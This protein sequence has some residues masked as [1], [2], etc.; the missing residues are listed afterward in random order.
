MKYILSLGLLFL[1]V[2]SFNQKIY[3]DNDYNPTKKKKKAV[4]YS[5]QEIKGELKSVVIYEMNGDK[6]SL[7]NY[8]H[9]LKHGMYKL[10]Y[11]NGELMEKGYYENG[12]KNGVSSIYYKNGKLEGKLHYKNDK[13][14]GM[15]SSYYYKTGQMITSVNYLDDLKEGIGYGYDRKGNLMS[16]IFYSNDKEN[17]LRIRFHENRKVRDS[18]RFVDGEIQ[19]FL[20]S[21]YETGEF[22]YKSLYKDNKIEG[23]VMKYWENGSKRDSA[24]YKN[25]ELQG[26]K[27]SWF[28]NGDLDKEIDFL[29]GKY[30][31][32]L[33]TYW[34]N[35]KVKRRDVYENDVLIEGN[36][37]SSQGLDTAF[38][39]YF[40]MPEFPGGV[41]K[42]YEF[43][44]KNI[45]YP[46]E[47]K[48]S[49]TKGKVY[50]QFVVERSGELVDVVVARGIGNGC[51]ME[52]IRVVKKMPKWNA[53]YQNGFAVRVK[54]T[55][56]VVYHL[57]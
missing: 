1:S 33:I 15:C 27:K 23:L 29:D 18:V 4:Y 51:D 25:G 43:L 22:R 39:D 21:Y 37:F 52:A 42:L 20:Y 28:E 56:P 40:I 26:N 19:G 49:G 45:R 7:Y 16:K 36:C 34:S 32:E 31:G 47:A 3:L 10:W 35:G 12:L 17:G 13:L 48:E 8:Q 30:D 11:L 54:Y 55:L 24:R 41:E 14:N 9:N 57:R 44:G 53:G 6:V 38:Y 2:L 46:Q 5:I 50:I